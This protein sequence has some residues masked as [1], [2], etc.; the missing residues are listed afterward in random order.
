MMGK[1]I[2][3]MGKTI[4]THQLATRN[5]VMQALNERASFVDLEPIRE[6]YESIWGD[7]LTWRY[8]ISDG[9]SAGAVI[10]PVQEGFLWLPYD[11]VDKE[12]MELISIDEIEFLDHEGVAVL[13]R[14]LKSYTDGLLDALDDMRTILQNALP[15]EK[16]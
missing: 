5:E 16:S 8:P 3:F 2:R 11:E 14:E 9:S 10:I 13:Y 12:L 4:N 6:R 7:D 1:N 15:G